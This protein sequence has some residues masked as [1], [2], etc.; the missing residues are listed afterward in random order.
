MGQRVIRLRFATHCA[1]CGRALPAAT[2]ARW[3]SGHKR[4]TCL[5]CAPTADPEP[6]PGTP[7][8]NPVP[9]SAARTAAGTPEPGTPG[10]SAQRIYDH[11]RRRRDERLARRF[12]PLAGLVRLLVAEPTSTR[13]WEQG[14]SGERRLAA[15]LTEQLGERAVMLHDRR[16]PGRRANIDHLAIAASGV[17]VIDAKAYGGL[18]ERRS[19][20][21]LLR[22]SERLYVNRRDQTQRL[23]ALGRQRDVVLGVLATAVDPSLHS[24]PPVHSALCFVGSQWHLLARPFELQGAWVTWPQDLAKRIGAP[25]PLSADDVQTLATRLARALPSA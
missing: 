24:A 5:E 14:A 20:G 12:G 22:S 10:A 3:D 11:R 23:E 9:P 18:V 2:R 21:S 13:V 1:G 16:I 4:A 7:R 19:R 25:G 15:V 17:W 6:P 8:R